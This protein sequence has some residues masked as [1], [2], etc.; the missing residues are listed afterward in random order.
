VADPRSLGGTPGLCKRRGTKRSKAG[1]A[2]GQNPAGEEVPELLLHEVRQA[3]ALGA[4]RRYAEKGFQVLADDRVENAPLR[5]A[6]L[7]G[8]VVPCRRAGRKPTGPGEAPHV[9][10]ATRCEVLRM[11]AAGGRFTVTMFIGLKI[12]PASR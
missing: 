5:R 4:L 6:R 3:G 9:T 7:V 11:L 1:E 12:S 8:S 2:V 10:P